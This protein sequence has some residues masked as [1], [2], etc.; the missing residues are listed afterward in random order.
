MNGITFIYILHSF[1]NYH[2]DKNDELIIMAPCTKPA[3]K[4]RLKDNNGAGALSVLHNQALTIAEALRNEKVKE[5]IR[6]NFQIYQGS[7][8][9]NDEIEAE[10]RNYAQ[11]SKDQPIDKKSP[12]RVKHF[13][14]I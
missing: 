6:D 11:L 9:F 14:T 5:Y 7:I 8:T 4:N 3:I 13:A 2:K 12:I 1:T 10:V